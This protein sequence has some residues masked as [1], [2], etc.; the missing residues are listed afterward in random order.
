MYRLGFLIVLACL[1]PLVLAGGDGSAW[2]DQG[3][4]AGRARYN[5]R[6][7]PGDEYRSVGL[8]TAGDEVEVLEENAEWH[9]VRTADGVEGWIDDDHLQTEPPPG[10]QIA[11]LESE[12]A[13]LRE[14]LAREGESAAQLRAEG[15]ALASAGDAQRA[16]IARLLGQAESLR[17]EGRWREWITGASIAFAGMVVGALLYRG[18][19]RRG[20]ASRLR[21]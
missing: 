8:V 3:W 18:M 2:A 21:F 10:A 15:E 11:S 1:G 13:S 19:T 6:R 9:R 17:V 16:E 14:R 4:I 12:L 7:G 5:L 20:S